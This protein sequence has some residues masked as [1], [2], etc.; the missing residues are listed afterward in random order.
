MS[1]CHPTVISWNNTTKHHDHSFLETKGQQYRFDKD[2]L[3]RFLKTTNYE[4][5]IEC[6]IFRSREY[7]RYEKERERPK[8]KTLYL[9]DANG[10]ISTIEGHSK[11]G[12]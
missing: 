7:S 11:L 3:L 2:A 8:I 6:T 4:L 1:I 12:K 5:I 10:T 9:I